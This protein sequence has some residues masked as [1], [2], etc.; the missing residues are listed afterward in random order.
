MGVAT[1]T[2]I[3]NE[4]DMVVFGDS[5]LKVDQDT[6]ARVL[7]ASYC[8][9]QVLMDTKKF[10]IVGID[11]DH[12]TRLIYFTETENDSTNFS[13]KSVFAGK[14]RKQ[15]SARRFN[16]YNWHVGFDAFH[17]VVDV[18]FV[19]GFAHSDFSRMSE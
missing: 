5:I 10:F 2:Q 19:F 13:L 3:V 15:H 18:Y 7:L 17:R 8:A 9:I 4:Y 11:S 1:N 6:I 16:G 14:D 12:I